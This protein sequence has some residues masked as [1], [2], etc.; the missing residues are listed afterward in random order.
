MGR[1]NPTF[2]DVLSGLE[3][4]W[5]DYRRG[6]RHADQDAFDALF[7]DARRHA[8][9][10]GL[11]NHPDPLVAVLPSIQIEQA[12]RIDALT[13]RVATLEARREDRP[14]TT[15]RAVPGTAESEGKAEPGADR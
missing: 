11:Q 2:R 13:T 12:K 3:A 6:L 9:A 1:T 7:A 10:C 4:D 8:D 15:D 14:V 5:Q